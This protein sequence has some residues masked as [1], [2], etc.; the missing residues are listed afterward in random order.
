MAKIPIQK[1]TPP[2]KERAKEMNELKQAGAEFVDV[3]NQMKEAMKKVSASSQDTVGEMRFMTG[4]QKQSL[5][6]AKQMERMTTTDLANAKKRNS[7]NKAVKETAAEIASQT[8]E[9]ASL[10]SK[11]VTAQKKIEKSKKT[12]SSETKNTSRESRDAI[13][14]AKKSIIVDEDKLK[15]AEAQVKELV[16]QKETSEALLKVAQKFGKTTQSV[17]RAASVFGGIAEVFAGIP[18][19]GPVFNGFAKSSQKMAEHVADGG[20]AASGMKDAFKDIMKLGLT[21]MIAMLW[22]GIQKIQAGAA[23]IR[24]ELGM[25]GEDAARAFSKASAAA[26][27]MGMPVSEAAGAVVGFNKALHTSAVVSKETNKYILGIANRMGLGAEAAAKLYKEAANSGKTLKEITDETVG[28][29]QKFNKANKVFLS[30][31]DIL[32]DVAN[33]SSQTALSTKKFPGGLKL[34]AAE[35]RKLGTDLSKSK[36]AMSGMLDFEQSLTAEMEAEM[37]LGR[38]L[39]LDKAR[40]AALNGDIAGFN[41]EIAKQGITAKSF[42]DMNVLQ[43]NAVAAALGK[44][45]ESLAAEL[46]SKETNK[47]L[48]EEALANGQKHNNSKLSE[49]ELG[50]QINEQALF[51]ATVAERLASAFEKIQL[52]LAEK[53]LPYLIDF[54][55]WITKSETNLGL[56]AAALTAIGAMSIIAPFKAAWNMT[57]SIVSTLTTAISKMLGLGKAAKNVAKGPQSQSLMS[58]AWGATKNAVKTGAGKIKNSSLGKAVGNA[59]KNIASKAT[60]AGQFVAT[61]AGNV[62]TGIG[63]AA[64]GAKDFVVKNASKAGQFVSEKTGEIFSMKGVGG[65]LG[66]LFK[67]MGKFARKVPVIGG[68]IETMLANHDMKALAASGASKEEIHHG[69]GKRGIQAITGMIGGAGAAAIVTALSAT[70]V[71]GFLVSGLAYTLGDMLGRGLGG[72]IADNAGSH[73]GAIG[74]SIAENFG[75]DKTIQATKEASDAAASS[76]TVG[77]PSIVTPK[78]EGTASN[79]LITKDFVIKP[80]NED[81]ITMAGGTK[82]GGNVESLLEQLIDIVSKGT[83]INLDGKLVGE[84][85]VMAATKQ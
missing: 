42:G 7:F 8:A 31:A 60:K 62:G 23:K 19:L 35:A 45:A 16:N 1:T 18:I 25:A 69:I 38:N 24:R 76:E 51:Q 27:G 29:T 53:I 80:L 64:K 39:N 59:G 70:G 56:V 20:S 13:Q 68:A 78:P 26:A 52:L 4:F 57:T 71:P 15:T 65:K 85:L 73:T 17:A 22:Q 72:L 82:L 47:V 48:E 54:A 9:I 36:D 12:I 32:N 81:T 63:N 77:S 74:K 21:T 40:L 67:G 2:T 37:L 30:G 11:I 10:S 6:L 83:V 66:K 75:Y 34:A 84:G 44:N 33:A 58:K 61:K 50:A 49:L 43:Q 41:R 5:E 28:F 14:A 55:N 46:K 79:P 3:L